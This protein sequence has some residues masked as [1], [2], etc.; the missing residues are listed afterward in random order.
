MHL[1]GIV[2]LNG[3]F[4]KLEDIENPK[5]RRVLHSRLRKDRFRFSGSG[6]REVNHQRKR[7]VDSHKNNYK[8]YHK[9]N[10]RDGHDDSEGYYDG[11][12]MRHGYDKSYNSGYSETI[13]RGYS[14]HTNHY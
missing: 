9:N 4:V 7:H 11:G 1:E 6:Y 13:D 10:H 8:E 12:G 3:K 5:L 14:E 2:E